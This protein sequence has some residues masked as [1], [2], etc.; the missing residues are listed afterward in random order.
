MISHDSPCHLSYRGGEL[1]VVVV[2]LGR[3]GLI[4][5]VHELGLHPVHHKAGEDERAWVAGLGAD[6]TEV[7]AL[8]I[9]R[10]DEEL[11][12]KPGPI[13]T[14]NNNHR[15]QRYSYYRPGM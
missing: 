15:P 7:D 6:P 2:E 14:P 9:C 3:V 13:P 1:H 10:V 11:G 8:P 5:R 12:R 4:E